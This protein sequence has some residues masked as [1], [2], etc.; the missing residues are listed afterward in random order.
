[1]LRVRGIR[2]RDVAA[3]ARRAKD[4]G[5]AAD[6]DDREAG[7]PAVAAAAA[8][9]LRQNADR[10]IARSLQNGVVA[11]SHRAAAAGGAPNPPS[12]SKPLAE[13]PLPVPGTDG[14]VPSSFGLDPTVPGPPHVGGAPAVVGGVQ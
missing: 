5:E 1:M 2:H 7:S 9:G 8:H 13:P 12:A 14:T 3:V 4:A 6:R 10:V 11:D